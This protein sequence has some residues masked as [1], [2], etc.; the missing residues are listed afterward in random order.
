VNHK[1]LVLESVLILH[2]IQIKELEN[3][4]EASQKVQQIT[5]LEEKIEILSRELNSCQSTN[6]ELEKWKTKLE[7]E[8]K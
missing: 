6:K 4:I 7:K 5:I 3:T 8:S 2:V 1:I